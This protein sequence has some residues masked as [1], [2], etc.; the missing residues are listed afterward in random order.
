[1]PRCAG[2][3]KSGGNSRPRPA[4]VPRARRAAFP[5]IPSLGANSQ[6]IPSAAVKI[7][8]VSPYDFAYPGG[9][10]NH[11]FYLERE[12]ARLG[13][14]TRIVAP[15]SDPAAVVQRH[16]R[17]T[18]IGKPTAIRT[19]GSI[20][21]IALSVRLSKQVKALLDQER[22]DIVHLHE[23]LMPMLPITFLRF[24]KSINVGTFHAY[25]DR[26]RFPTEAYFY[27]RR[28][29]G[30]WFR[31]LHGRIAVSEPARQFV[32]Q[33]LPS[34]YIVIPNGI[35]L[36]RFATPRPPLAQ[37]ADGKI[38]LLFVG[39]WEPRKGLKYLIRAF[40]LVHEEFPNTRLIV[41]G[42][43]GGHRAAMAQSL[44]GMGLAA[45]VDLVGP[46]SDELLPRYYQ[47]AD[48]FCYPATGSESMGI[49]LLEAMAAGKPLVAS[50]TQGAVHV[51][52]DDGEG[53]LVPPKDH[54][55][56]AMALAHLLADENLRMQMGAQGRETAQAYSW[57]RIAI[58]ILAYYEELS[59]HRPE[60]AQPVFS[61]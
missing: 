11:I 52:C 20:A 29:I 54:T 60:P 2:A 9:A 18:V 28:I 43:D 53:V 21:R 6:A 36:E 19:G 34:E 10:N 8:Q 42:P 57:S 32:Q 39:R 7:A 22:F 44:M 38:N 30:R 45:D 26:R 27:G 59:R 25:H 24:S 37:Y 47:T 14:E 1:M 23:P 55:A 31:R 48:I 56:L 58:R 51:V 50:A 16:P 15:A 49:V 3:T 5:L 35:D 13:H 17:L 12:L 40:A 4:A 33:Y 61:Q 46:V 41:V